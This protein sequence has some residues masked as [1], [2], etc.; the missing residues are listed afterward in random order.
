MG[1]VES[2]GNGRSKKEIRGGIRIPVEDA[3]E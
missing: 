3:K 1:L 2:K